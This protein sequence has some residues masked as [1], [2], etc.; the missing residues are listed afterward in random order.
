MNAYELAD[1]VKRFAEQIKPTNNESDDA[2]VQGLPNWFID[3][4]EKSANMLR[5]QA[6]RIAEL[7][8][9]LIAE[10]EHNLMLGETKPCNGFCGEYECKENQANC[11]RLKNATHQ[12]TDEEIT[13]IA[14]KIGLIVEEQ[15][16]EDY[17]HD[18]VVEQIEFARAIEAKLKGL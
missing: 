13:Q 15:L 1:I 10:Q 7:E 5:Q 11:S 6:D 17:A 3:A 18:Y 9:C 12:L 4:L 16:T 8:K 14:L 2:V